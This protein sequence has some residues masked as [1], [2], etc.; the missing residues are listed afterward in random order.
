MKSVDGGQKEKVDSCKITADDYWGFKVKDLKA[1]ENGKKVEYTITVDGIKNYEMSVS[2][3][4]G[5]S[6]EITCTYKAQADT[7]KTGDTTNLV[8]MISMLGLSLAAMGG[9]VLGRKK[10]RE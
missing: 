7:P 6:F 8:M 3:S 1:Y 9:L 4:T 10:I 5:K 2:G